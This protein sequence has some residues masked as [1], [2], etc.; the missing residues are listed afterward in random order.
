MFKKTAITFNFTESLFEKRVERNNNE[1]LKNVLG[2]R[3]TLFTR[4][5]LL[6]SAR[7]N[8]LIICTHSRDIA[9][10]Y[11]T[12]PVIGSFPCRMIRRLICAAV[13]L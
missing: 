3:A 1:E 8:Y 2:Y 11:F 9:V 5:L 7:R 10:T 6:F 13:K 4:F 12:A